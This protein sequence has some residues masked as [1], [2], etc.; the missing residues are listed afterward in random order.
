MTAIE[1]CQACATG[2][3]AEQLPEFASS[4]PAS[5][6]LISVATTKH[7]AIIGSELAV[8]REIENKDVVRG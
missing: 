2:H 4:N 8:S 6:E 7:E 5:T 1:N 3:T